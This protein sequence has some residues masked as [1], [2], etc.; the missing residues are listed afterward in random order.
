MQHDS[1][2][3]ALLSQTR[4]YIQSSFFEVVLANCLD[5]VTVTLLDDLGENALGVPQV[6]RDKPDL[7]PGLAQEPR[8][9]LA[10]ILPELALWGR[11]A[12]ES[13]PNEIVK[14]RIHPGVLHF[15]RVRFAH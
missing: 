13:V 15:I 3:M 9:C 1:S 10:G 5:R 11:L 14:V 6:E 8:M 2:F 7:P 4:T 12:L